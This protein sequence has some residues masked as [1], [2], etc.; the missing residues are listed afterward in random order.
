MIQILNPYKINQLT[1]KV[2]DF[3]SVW[4]QLIKIKSLY[5]SNVCPQQWFTVDTVEQLKRINS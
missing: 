1:K 4:E 3:Y 2:D 5:S